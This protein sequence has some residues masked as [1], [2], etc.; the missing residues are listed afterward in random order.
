MVDEDQVETSIKFQ[1]FTLTLYGTVMDDNP[2]L[3]SSVLMDPAGDI[4]HE[5]V[6]FDGV[7]NCIGVV[8][9]EKGGEAYVAAQLKDDVGG[10]LPEG[11]DEDGTLV[12][13]HVHHHVLPAEGVY[14][15]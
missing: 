13:A 12:F 15:V 3:K 6:G 10:S 7:D 14:S 1:K 8:G 2:I 11:V 5:V 4:G 9:H